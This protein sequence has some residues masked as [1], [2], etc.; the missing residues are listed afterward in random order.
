VLESLAGN[1][2]L[3][4]LRSLVYERKSLRRVADRV[5]TLSPPSSQSN[6]SDEQV[7]DNVMTD[8]VLCGARNS[9]TLALI[10][11]LL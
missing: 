8:E 11:Y 2:R 4:C 5:P 10:I 9:S 7:I 3:S 6:L 1:I